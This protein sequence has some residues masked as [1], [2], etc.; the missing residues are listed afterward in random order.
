MKDVKID[1]KMPNNDITIYCDDFID[2]KCHDEIR[3]CD[4]RRLRIFTYNYND[5]IES[6][7]IDIYGDVDICVTDLYEIENGII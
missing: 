7:N 2:E 6:S 4:F 3:N 5:E 1:I